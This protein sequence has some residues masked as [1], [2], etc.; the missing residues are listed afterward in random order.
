MQENMCVK[1]SS[2]AVTSSFITWTA[3]AERSLYFPFVKLEGLQYAR[4]RRE[5][6][7][8]HLTP[9]PGYCKII[10]FRTGK[11][12]LFVLKASEISIFREVF[13]EVSLLAVPSPRRVAPYQLSKVPGG[14]YLE[15]DFWYL[16]ISKYI[17]CF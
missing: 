3:V 16:K 6:G 13:L 2:A 1:W 10:A 8:N 17:I 4:L 7:I 15:Q 5:A 14:H 12:P 9:R 11:L